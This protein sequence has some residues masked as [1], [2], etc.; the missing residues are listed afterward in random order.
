MSRLSR[1]LFFLIALVCAFAISMAVYKRL[2]RPPQIEMV[3]SEQAIKQIVV[4]FKSFQ[5]GQVI[6]ATDLKLAPY[7]QES[8]PPGHFENVEDV[9]GRVV[10]Q[11][12]N[13][14][15]PVLESQLAGKDL[16]KGG[17]A[18]IISH[19]KRAMAV[20]VDNVIGVA[21]FIQPGNMVDVLVT[22]TPDSEQARALIADGKTGG[23]DVNSQV[24]KTV[25][26]NVPVLAIGS[27]AEESSD[28]KPQQVTVATLEV[29]PEEAEK[30]GLAVMQGSILLMLR[31]YTDQAEVPTSGASVVSLLKS[32][33]LHAM[34]LPADETT[35]IPPAQA[36]VYSP[37]PRRPRTL[38]IIN[39]NKVETKQFD[40]QTGA[41]GG[42]R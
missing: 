28:K 25:L 10:L 5:R 2:S 41:R 7:L 31:N 36:P 9:A 17:L 24:A 6:Q 11:P 3:T 27:Q 16:S 38:T 30:L 8:L 35:Y 34:S 13:V 14:S 20:K 26:E 39:G 4:A 42:E 23:A 40:R 37:A 22:V 29:T 33:Q 19:N 18:A 15:Q 21:G 32:N 12:I 1:L